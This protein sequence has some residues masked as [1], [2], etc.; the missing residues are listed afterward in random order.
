MRTALI[1]LLLLSGFYLMTAEVVHGDG[2][3]RVDLAVTHF[4][5]SRRR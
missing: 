2:S 5:D 4:G 3:F 1:A